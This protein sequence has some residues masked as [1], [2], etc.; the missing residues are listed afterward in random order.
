MLFGTNPIAVKKIITEETKDPDEE[1]R[2]KPGYNGQRFSSLHEGNCKKGIFPKLEKPPAVGECSI[3]DF[4]LFI[5][6]INCFC[7]IA[8]DNIYGLFF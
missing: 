1:N 3:F 8:T 7:I 2:D 5:F 6:N 4:H